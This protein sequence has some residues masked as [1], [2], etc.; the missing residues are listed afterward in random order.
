[1]ID[2]TVYDPPMHYKVIH[3]TR[4]IYN[5]P[6][7]LCHNIAR[8]IPR[9]TGRQTCKNS[10]VTIDPV[11]DVLNEY[12]DF[13][14]NRVTYFAVQHEHTSLTVTVSSEIVTPMSGA[15]E[16]DFHSPVAW[17]EVKR[18]LA[19]SRQ[20]YSNVLQ[21]IPETPLT[22]A[23][24]AISAYALQS[25]RPGRS[26]FEATRELM[27]RIFTDFR[28]QPG[29]TT[30]TTPLSEVMSARKG[31]CQDFAHLGIACLRSLGLPARYISGY[32][33]TIPP[34]GTKKLAGVDASHAWFSVFIPGTGWIDFDPTNNQFPGDQHLVIGWGRDYS[35]IS[36]LKGVV[37][38]SGPHRLSVSVDVR[39]V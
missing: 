30:I 6:V 26:L 12:E 16:I 35:D 10:V 32:I 15:P 24:P 25:F 18:L 27:Q 17:E 20:E 2:Y 1:M 36:P 5:E 21:Y 8:L 9:S 39:R 38:S 22:A 28:F 13:F 11:P 37:V 33:E 31:V 14:G 3:T 19:A 23:D 29:F 4:Y 7:S 34:A